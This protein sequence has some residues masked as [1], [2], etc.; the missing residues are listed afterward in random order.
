MIVDHSAFLRDRLASFQGRAKEL[1]EIR[2]RVA[3]RQQTGG[4][5]TITGRAGQ[6]KSSVIA[7]LVEERAAEQEQGPDGVAFHFIPLNPGRDHQFGLLRNLMARLILKYDLPDLYVDGQSTAALRDY[8]PGVLKEIAKKRR[9]EIIFIDG[10]DQLEGD[11]FGNG[12]QGKRDLSF[13]PNDV[14]S[15][16]VF[17][18][19]T[20]PND[21]LR[22][23]QLLKPRDEYE[24][25]N[26]SRD[27]FDLILRH[28]GSVLEPH[29]ADQFYQVLDENALFL[30]LA[31]TELTEHGPITTAEVEVII[32]LVTENPENLFGLAIE[33]LSQGG[34]SWEQ[35]IKPILGVL[36]VAREPLDRYHLKQIV[37][38]NH[39]QPVDGGQISEGLERLG[40][41]VIRDGQQC[42][43]LSH[44]KLGEYLREDAARPYKRFVCDSEDVQHLH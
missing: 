11:E 8:F 14:P 44:L 30:D 13:L 15:G 36:L 18:L 38:L 10:L 27:D 17:V 6:G 29:I 5:V 33:R 35:V 28:H 9:Q 22:P 32:K 21:T 7:K 3:E 16:V 19:G 24:L 43:T 31:S 23:L 40:G 37:N 39:A 20:R 26:L 1:A 2:Q 42:Y 34:I 25:P 12:L 41:L 4:Y